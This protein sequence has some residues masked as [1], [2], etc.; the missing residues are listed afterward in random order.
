MNLLLSPGTATPSHVADYA[1]V[2]IFILV[3]FVFA[4]IA[5]GVAKLLRPSKPSPAKLT[6]YECGELP[7]G[8]SWVRFNVR[9]YLVALFFIVFD[10]EV[11]FLY[12]WAVVFKQL[13][14]VPQLGALVFWEM[15]IFLAI[16]SVGLAYVWVKGDLAWVKKLVDRTPAESA[17]PA[18]L[19]EEVSAP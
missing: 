11:I 13:Y 10:V 15:I 1:T 5:L 7:T 16:L 12:P 18:V 6:T 19:E 14:P 2:L 4:G 9:F 3:G 8:S 17:T